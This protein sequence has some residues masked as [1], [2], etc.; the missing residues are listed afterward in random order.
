MFE[1]QNPNPPS[2]FGSLANDKA[3]KPAKGRYSSTPNKKKGQYS[4]SARI[5]WL[6][7]IP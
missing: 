4:N 3:Q 5:S 6:I 2:L 7:S 1:V